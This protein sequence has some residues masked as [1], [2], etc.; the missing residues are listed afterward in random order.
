[1]AREPAEFPGP[2]VEIGGDLNGVAP[3]N[4]EPSVK[5]R[6]VDSHCHLFLCKGEPSAL[7]ESARE[8][9]VSIF[10]C[11]GL[12]PKSSHDAVT[13]AEANKGVFATS[14]MHPHTASGLDPRARDEIEALAANPL[15][16]GVGET[17]LDFHRML[18]PREDQ[19]AAFRWH[20]GVARACGKPVVVHIRD[21]WERALEVLEE[22]RA[23]RVVLHCF[24]GDSVAA[25][26]CV[27]RG[28]FVSFA[29]SITY[30]K[31]QHLRDAAAVVPS[32]RLL[33]ETDSPYLS[34]QGLR[35]REN[36][37]ANVVSVV[38]EL[39][40]AREQSFGKV[41][42]ATWGAARAAFPGL[43]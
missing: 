29:G 12:D 11:V 40:I 15:V 9:G 34:P 7:L 4:P 37:P 14:G 3:A 10:V 23:D 25:R 27:A 20:I 18:S 30:P 35:G 22:E 21:A 39:A 2:K 28:Y 8:V 36:S 32:D 13:L 5:P 17:G 43:G 42:G 31:N 19:E 24:S 33:T 38:E 16:V 6:V 1:V 41:A 26:G